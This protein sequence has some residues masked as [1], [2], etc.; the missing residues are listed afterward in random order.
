[1]PKKASSPRKS[2]S[3]KE[4]PRNTAADVKYALQWLE[5]RGSQKNRD[6]MARYAIVAKK[7]FVV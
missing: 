4:R 7:V 5:R 3:R 6:G 2:A 1:M